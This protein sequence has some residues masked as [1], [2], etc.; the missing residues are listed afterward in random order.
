MTVPASTGSMLVIDAGNTRTKWAVCSAEHQFGTPFEAGGVFINAALPNA[1]IP[2]VWRNCRR[3]V[4]A[5]VASVAVMA[6][7]EPML[8][9]LALDVDRVNTTAQ[10]CGLQNGYAEPLQLGVDRWLAAIAAWRHCQAPCIVACA[11]TAL[12]VDAVGARQ[13][14]GQGLLLGGLI[15]PGF[16]LMQHSL[17]E[18]TAAISTAAGAL[19]TFPD[20]T[21]DGVYN[22]ATVAMTGAIL[23]MLGQ[24][25]YREGRPPRCI[26]SGGDAALL[27]EAL[28]LQHGSDDSVTVIDN[29]VLQGLQ[30]IERERP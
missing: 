22:G 27:A 11:G 24:L 7:I 13:G 23:H 18:G 29:L 21:S 30:L 9:T 2:E 4:I 26:V 17:L 16:R 10:A 5:S 6:Q 8:Q 28:A 20:N 14:N 15:V 19:R 25:H 3:A 1:V 12:T